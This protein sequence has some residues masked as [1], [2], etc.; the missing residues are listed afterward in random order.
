VRYVLALLEELVVRC[1]LDLIQQQHSLREMF[2]FLGDIQPRHGEELLRICSPLFVLQPSISDMAMLPLRKSL[3]SRNEP[4]RV[5]ASWGLIHLLHVASSGQGNSFG[6]QSQSNNFNDSGLSVEELMTLLRR[7]LTQQCSVRKVVYA[8]LAECFQAHKSLRRPIYAFISSQLRR[9]VTTRNGRS[10]FDLDSCIVLSPSP[11]VV[12]PL[13][14][15]ITCA[16]TVIN[17]DQ[18]DDSESLKS[19]L[20]K[21]AKELESL[22]LSD[23]LDD[24]HDFAQVG[25]GVVIFFRR[26]L[27]FFVIGLFCNNVLESPQLVLKSCFCY[28]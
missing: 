23:Y 17:L 27:F 13:G 14:H 21:L 24:P 19:D 28:V 10:H 4:T 1:P 18:V 26:L 3:F 11:H 15:L 20:S 12:E 2:S 16:S 6:S 8:G 22:N 5:M 9:Y 7:C 25:G